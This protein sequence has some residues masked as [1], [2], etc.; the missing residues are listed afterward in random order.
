MNVPIESNIFIALFLIVCAFL[1][2]KYPRLINGYS[3]IMEE[4]NSEEKMAKV[5][6]STYKSMLAT[7]LVML[8][9]SVVAYILQAS[10]VASLFTL[11]PILIMS[12]YIVLKM[13]QI[14]T[15]KKNINYT[16]F[17]LVVLSVMTIGLCL[18][19]LK[20]YL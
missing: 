2:K 18:I 16:R 5:I 13:S 8:I 11:L 19:M 3:R 15:L 4:D 12:F 17:S 1:V 9:T 7:S 10:R 6:S 20:P 14:V